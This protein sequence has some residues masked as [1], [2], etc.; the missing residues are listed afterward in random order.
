MIEAFLEAERRP[1][2]RWSALQRGHL[3]TKK[4]LQI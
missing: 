1:P 3:A 4:I 2:D